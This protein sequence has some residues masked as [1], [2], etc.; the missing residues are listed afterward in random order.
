[1]QRAPMR[2]KRSQRGVGGVGRKGMSYGTVQIE[3]RSQGRQKR[4]MQGR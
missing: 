4:S 1:M 3:W 2:E